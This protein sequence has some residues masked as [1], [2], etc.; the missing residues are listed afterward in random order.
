MEKHLSE[1]DKSFEN[2]K[3][4]QVFYKRIQAYNSLDRICKSFKVCESKTYSKS[5]NEALKSPTEV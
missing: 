5:F 1:P 2:L 3:E 4:F